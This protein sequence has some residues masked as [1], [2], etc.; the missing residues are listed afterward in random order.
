[1][2]VSYQFVSYLDS[3]SG[4]GLVADLCYDSLSSLTFGWLTDEI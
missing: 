4:A 3:L 1:M 2:S